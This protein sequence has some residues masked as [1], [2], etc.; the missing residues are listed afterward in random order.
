MLGKL[1]KYEWKGLKKPLIIFSII[2]VVTTILFAFTI[3]MIDSNR[4]VNSNF[5]PILATI[6][7][8]FSYYLSILACTLGIPLVLAI[9]FYK[10]CYTDQG[11]LTHTLPVS[12]LELL[13]SKV[14]AGFLSTLWISLLISG[15]IYAVIVIGGLH[16]SSAL[17][18]NFFNTMSSLYSEVYTA[19]AEET[20]KS[21]TAL[22]VVSIIYY[23][24][25]LIGGC[26]TFFGC[27]SLGQLYTKHR[28]LGAILAY[29]VVM[30]I[31]RN[32]ITITTFGNTFKN[33]MNNSDGMG[34]L[35]STY[36]LTFI[37]MIIL[38][39]GM[40]FVSYYMMNKKLNLE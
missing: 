20:G 12:T 32:I 30:F 14:L 17:D 16:L 31:T 18:F 25:A 3:L 4:N 1:L 10:T 37:S 8:G 23:I 35:F 15:S 9:R 33:V 40:F 39:I 21:L 2:I 19:Y 5:G 26:C 6:L 7:S 11:Y 28:V 13:S 36:R 38:G 22:I 24:L 34:F 27:V 29:L